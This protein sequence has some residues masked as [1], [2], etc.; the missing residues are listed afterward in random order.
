MYPLYVNIEK[1][2]IENENYRNVIFTGKFQLVLMSLKPGEE[3]GNEVHNDV[4]QF[5]RIEKGTAHFL[6]DNS[7]HLSAK[8]GDAVVVPAGTWHNVINASNRADLKLYT[9]YA[10]PDH[11]SGLI[12]KNKPNE[13]KKVCRASIA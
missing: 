5:F 3:I 12:E 11:P 13:R 8:N 6:I 1:E 7:I 10:P 2:T 9:I 4:D